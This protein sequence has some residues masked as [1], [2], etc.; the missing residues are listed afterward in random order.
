M[1][2]AFKSIKTILGWNLYPL[3]LKRESVCL[4]SRDLLGRNQ[5]GTPFEIEARR[6]R[7]VGIGY[8]VYHPSLALPEV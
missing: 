6:K 3:F 7:N 2:K 1:A 4:I 8:E 5:S